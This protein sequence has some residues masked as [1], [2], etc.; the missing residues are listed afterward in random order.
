MITKGKYPFDVID[1]GKSD[2]DTPNRNNKKSKS[3]KYT[4]NQRPNNALRRTFTGEASTDPAGLAY[5]GLSSMAGEGAEQIMSDALDLGT[6]TKSGFMRD[7]IGR[8]MDAHEHGFDHLDV[9]WNPTKNYREFV[10][11]ST[12]SAGFHRI[13]L[14]GHPPMLPNVNYFDDLEIL[15]RFDLSATISS[16][17]T[18]DEIYDI[19]TKDDLRALYKSKINTP[20]TPGYRDDLHVATPPVDS[21]YSPLI[22]KVHD[23]FCQ[24]MREGK[25]EFFYLVMREQDN[26]PLPV[27]MDQHITPTVMNNASK[28]TYTPPFKA[29]L[30]MSVNLSFDEQI[31]SGKFNPKTID[32][33]S[34]LITN[35]HDCINAVE[36]RQAHKTFKSY[37]KRGPKPPG[38]DW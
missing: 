30:A 31:C 35:P 28:L 10:A 7:V 16:Q 1:G 29:L 2:I 24:K 3:L 26:M 20:S 15:F 23:M 11:Y 19:N 8:F 14:D 38:S 22:Q 12:L 17:I 27:T 34:E 18:A 21:P 9:F 5:F 33:W 4:R 25:H 36:L 32:N 13:P 37:N 6:L